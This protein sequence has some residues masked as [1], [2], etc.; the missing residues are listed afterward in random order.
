MA[1]LGFI[2]IPRGARTRQIERGPRGAEVVAVGGS[3][4]GRVTRA[5]GEGRRGAAVGEVLEMRQQ[6][7]DRSLDEVRQSEQ[8]G[9]A[10]TRGAL[11]V[12]SLSLRKASMTVTSA[13][14]SRP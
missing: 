11:S 9:R 1:I 3:Q 7:G 4:E 12:L 2:L 6:R 13:L 10:P 5:T 8:D 14:E